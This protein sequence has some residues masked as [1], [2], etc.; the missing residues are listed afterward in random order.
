MAR[1]CSGYSPEPRQR[2]TDRS[3]IE[4]LKADLRWALELARKRKA[5]RNYT[6]E[7]KKLNDLLNELDKEQP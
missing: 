4:R 7:D 5:T 3:E 6:T 1:D 2:P